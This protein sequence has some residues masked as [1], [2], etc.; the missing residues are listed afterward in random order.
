MYYQ[1]AYMAVN[2]GHLFTCKL[3]IGTSRYVILQ[4]DAETGKIETHRSYG[5]ESF[6]R[7]QRVT[8]LTN[9]CNWMAENFENKI[10]DWYGNRLQN[11]H[12]LRKRHKGICTCKILPW[13][14]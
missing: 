3:K 2:D 5:M 4:K 8:C 11:S 12:T 6:R 9:L 7:K 14:R 1:S 10:K 13:Q